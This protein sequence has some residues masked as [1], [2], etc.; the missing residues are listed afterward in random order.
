LA[1]RRVLKIERLIRKVRGVADHVPAAR[2][3]DGSEGEEKGSHIEELPAGGF[4]GTALARRLLILNPEGAGGGVRIFLGIFGI[5]LVLIVVADVL[6]TT[7]RLTGGGPIT[8]R[9]TP[10]LWRA[11]VRLAPGHRSLS[12][13]GFAIVLFEM[14]FWV[15]LVWIGWTLVLS[16]GAGSLVDAKTQTPVGFLDRLFFIGSSLVTVGTGKYEPTSTA[17]QLVATVASANGF[18][19]ITLVITYLLPLV[20]EVVKR[21]Q[22]A[23][24]IAGMGDTPQRILVQAWNGDGF[25]LLS[26]HWIQLSFPMQQL[27]QGHLAYPILHCFHSPERN[28]AL[29]PNVAILDE[30]MTLMEC[31]VPEK[32]PDPVACYPLR[33]AI[34]SFLETLTE[35]HLSPTKEPPPPPSLEP[36][37][38]AG[39]PV[40]GE[41]ELAKIL[42]ASVKRRRL[43][44]GLV[45]REGW[46][47]KDL[48]GDRQDRDRGE[49]Q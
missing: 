29:A 11:A 4:P 26:Q 18:F 13:M 25:G 19:L 43:L 17:W 7:L 14:A 20:T 24:Y 6:G 30:A 48:S 35:A 33:C 27:G 8:S 9:L 3:E 32:R 40:L 10:W 31:V 2:Q 49:D 44:R 34:E 47:W 45:D 12:L 22:I 41:G 28:T 1:D 16:M 5:I 23:S 38:A 37:R 36:L 42:D 39:I 15:G 46:S 21:R